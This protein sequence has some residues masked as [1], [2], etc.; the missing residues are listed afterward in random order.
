MRDP[1]VIKTV[2]R[3]M[4]IGGSGT[5]LQPEACLAKRGFVRWKKLPATDFHPESAATKNCSLCIQKQHRLGELLLLGNDQSMAMAIAMA[6]AMAMAATSNGNS[7]RYWKGK[8][9]YWSR[10]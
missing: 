8:I 1:K 7:T 9:I 3:E 10:V 5:L 6:M 4:T 2:E